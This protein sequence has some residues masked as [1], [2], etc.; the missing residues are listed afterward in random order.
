M[1]LKVDHCKLQLCFF[2]FRTSQQTNNFFFKEMY[3]CIRFHF[4]LFFSFGFFL[5]LLKIFFKLQFLHLRH[6]F[7]RLIKPIS[8]K[9]QQNLELCDVIIFNLICTIEGG[10]VQEFSLCFLTYYNY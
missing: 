8:L 10:T 9:I 4:V 5:R 3:N 1:I 7:C 2:L 6:K